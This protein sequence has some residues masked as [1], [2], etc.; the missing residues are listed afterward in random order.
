[1]I[2]EGRNPVLEALKGKREIYRLLVA[3]DVE[4][5]FR[6]NLEELA[7]KKGV[8]V[9]VV[10]NS[11]LREYS[12]TGASQGVM[13][14][15]NDKKLLGLKEL[16]ELPVK[17]KEPLYLILDGIE[18]PRNFGAILRSADGFGVDGV[19][20]RERRSVGLTPAAIKASAGAFEYVNICQVVNIAQAITELKKYG[21]WIA[22]TAGDADMTVYKADLKSP[23]GIV[24]GNEGKGISRLVR[25]KCDF[26]ISIPM[27]GTLSSL[28]V[29]VAVG[30]VLYEVARQR[31]G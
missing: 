15:S 8:F 17:G 7:R 21:I 6:Q 10:S 13:A 3:Q 27:L 12:Q 24:V 31:R 1:L 29:S 28:N 16:L 11:E 4:S 26:V 5:R 2:I 22:G 19:I 9:E 18:D 25:E 20:I 23:L 30:V 14:F